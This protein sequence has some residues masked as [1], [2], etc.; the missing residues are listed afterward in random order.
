MWLKCSV[1]AYLWSAERHIANIYSVGCVGLHIAPSR[2]IM[3]YTTIA[4]VC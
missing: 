3:L 4:R 2:D 1:S